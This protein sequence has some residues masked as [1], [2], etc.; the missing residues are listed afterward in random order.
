MGNVSQGGDESS[1]GGTILRS[2]PC[3]V[4]KEQTFLQFTKLHDYIH[5]HPCI[6]VYTNEPEF[7]HMQIYW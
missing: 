3:T 5:I 6:Y 4:T 2:T 7:I 1:T